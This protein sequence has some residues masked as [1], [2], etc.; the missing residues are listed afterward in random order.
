VVDKKTVTVHTKYGVTGNNN[1]VTKEKDRL[2]I[3]NADP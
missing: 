3:T 2:F 1:E